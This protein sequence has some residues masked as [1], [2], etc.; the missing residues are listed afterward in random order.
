M[1]K[2]SIANIIRQKMQKGDGTVREIHQRLNADP[3]VKKLLAGKEIP[4]QTV[5]TTLHKGDVKRNPRGFCRSEGSPLCYS[6][7]ATT[8][9]APEPCDSTPDS[10]SIDSSM[11]PLLPV[12]ADF[13]QAAGTARLIEILAAAAKQ[14][15][16]PI[17]LQHEKRA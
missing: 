2:N 8:I 17:V 13:I 11:L 14:S 12:I 1:K 16:F 5:A 6:L 10:R 4:M 15:T 9:A 3:K 7:T